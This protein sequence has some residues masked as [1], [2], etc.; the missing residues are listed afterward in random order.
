[1]DIG[2]N[3]T[4]IF[5]RRT[6]EEKAARR[7]KWEERRQA[8]RAR[9]ESDKAARKQAE[10]DALKALLQPGEEIELQLTTGEVIM[11][12][13]V[14]VT[15]KRLILA[16]GGAA[17]SAKSIPFRSITALDTS[18][19]VTHDLRLTIQ[20]EK[21]KLELTFKEKADRDRLRDALTKHTLDA[22]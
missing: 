8:S 22:D 21:D 9:W 6:P 2:D 7:A 11:K 4:V 5:R 13:E 10:T 17:S 14:I 3:P 1:L 19:F 16:P 15:S 18:Q 20:G 12:K